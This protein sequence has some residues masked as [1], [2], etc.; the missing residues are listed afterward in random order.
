MAL[1]EYVAMCEGL[2]GR[3]LVERLRQLVPA[4]SRVLEIGSGPA[5][6]LLI[7]SESFEVTGSDPS[8]AFRRRFARL[9]ADQKI[10]Y[11]DL[12][13]RTLKVE[14]P[15]AHYDAIYSNKVLHHLEPE[16]HR[17]SVAAQRNLLTLGGVVLHS[18]WHGAHNSK[19]G[20]LLLNQYR[21]DAL[22]ELW[23][24]PNTTHGQRAWTV[25][26]I[27][28]YSELGFDDSLCLTARAI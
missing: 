25:L 5:I 1:K 21:A 2:D 28:P 4:H 17:A 10:D 7:L 18:Y 12:D 8:A 26:D 24:S 19:H 14:V 27:A 16:A 6:D 22:Q 11:L 13:A 9:H 20:D 23:E 15:A 3:A